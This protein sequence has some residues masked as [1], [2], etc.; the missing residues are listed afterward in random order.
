VPQ[1]LIYTP[2]GKKRAVPL[3]SA[4][5]TLGRSSS[6]DL[7]FADDNGL[8]RLHLEFERSDDDVIA[9]DLKSKN[10]TLVN[11]ERLSNPVRLRPNDKVS[12]GH[13]LIVF[14]PPGRSAGV[15]FIDDDTAK[16]DAGKIVTSLHGVMD[17]STK[18]VGS[19]AQVSALIRAGNELA[20]ERP[21][22]DL[23][24]IILDLSIDAVSAG[25]GVV[26]T[27]EG[28]QLVER[29][30]RGDNFSISRA[31]RDQVMETKLSVL[32]RDTSLD[33]ALK[34]RRSIIASR[35]RTLM[36]VPLQVRDQVM[37]LIYVDSPSLHRE[38]T[39]D[40]LSLLT[41]MANVAAI[42]IEH[43]RLAEIEQARKVM[44]HELKQA[45]A[46]QR[47]AL[48]AAAP[49]IAGLDIAGY[50]AASRSVG[51]D[52]YD[53]FTDNTG[54]AAIILADVS[55]KGM[56]A[57]LMVMALQARVQPLFET[58]PVAPGAL[59]IAMDRLNRLTT[60]N[61]PLGRFITLFACVLNGKNGHFSWSC[62]GH[63]PPLIVRAG[64]SSERLEGGGPIMGVFEDSDYEQ[65]RAEL[66]PGDLLAIY[67]DG[68]TE[69]CSPAEEEFDMDRLA[70]VLAEHR[71]E[72]ADQIAQAVALAVQEWSCGAP[73]ADDITVVIAKK[74]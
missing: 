37:G 5:T 6:A 67:S 24:R 13:L 30:S 56:P 28:G 48:P 21:L 51:G 2:D 38:F 44:E 58:V 50:N 15:V 47:G 35:V 7:C 36:A 57:A 22:P 27:S 74:L 68:V 49:A 65:E 16:T 55:G 14:D 3:D 18:G 59:K 69:A 70:K 32:V 12:C 34:S 29:A 10:G 63:N 52:Y 61:C 64:G 43:A 45:E 33:D 1:I 60:A 53:F 4:R 54:H 23:F 20:S 9:R 19:A 72:S 17:E 62:A 26:L 41:V 73:P 46:I 8:S 39:K 42:R 66:A 71:R 40:D 31:V 25:R 11:G